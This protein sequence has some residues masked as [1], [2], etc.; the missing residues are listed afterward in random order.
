MANPFKEAAEKKKKSPGGAAEGTVEVQ[1]VA[2]VEEVVPVQQTQ[3]AVV[4]EPVVESRIP[5]PVEETQNTEITAEQ[6]EKLDKTLFSSYAE[7]FKPPAPPRNVRF[8]IVIPVS[9]A[10]KLEKLRK[11][12]KIKSK[13]DLINFLLERYFEDAE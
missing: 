10:E 13:N 5:E 12:Q 4:P 11:E 2:P 8:Q 6:T 1:E 9:I 7:A 3:E